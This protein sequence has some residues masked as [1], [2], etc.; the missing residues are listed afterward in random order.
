MFEAKTPLSFL[1]F[2]ILTILGACLAYGLVALKTWARSFMIFFSGLHIFL[3]WFLI[4]LLFV[5]Q[6]DLWRLSIAELIHSDK[7]SGEQFLGV[8]IHKII[9]IKACVWT[10]VYGLLIIYFFRPS[11][12][13]LFL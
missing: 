3:A 8:V 4:L 13:R 9:F 7:M 2:M 1:Y 12:R 5:S 11:I 6:D 10:V